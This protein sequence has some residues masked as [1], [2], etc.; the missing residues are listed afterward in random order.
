MRCDRDEMAFH[1]SSPCWNSLSMINWE[2]HAPLV[3][4]D[5]GNVI[6]NNR[7]DDI[8]MRQR[9]HMTGTMYNLQSAARDSLCNDLGHPAFQRIR[10]FQHERRLTGCGDC[11]KFSPKAEAIIDGLMAHTKLEICNT[12]TIS[13]ECNDTRNGN[14]AVAH[15]NL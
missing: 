12:C 13:E 9:R 2:I 3:P 6:I 1:R 11:A 10:I 8:R 15:A 14:A 5:G 4:S 7:R